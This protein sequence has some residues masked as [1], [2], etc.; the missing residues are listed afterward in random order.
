MKIEQR[1]T[2]QDLDA[3]QDAFI[4][5]DDYFRSII[6]I[7][8]FSL[9]NFLKVPAR[10]GEGQEQRLLLNKEQFVNA[11]SSLVR[12]GTKDEARVLSSNMLLAF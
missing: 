9:I 3:L 1:L 11:M 8:W 5:R 6:D 10:D 7:N 2:S 4:V 12:K